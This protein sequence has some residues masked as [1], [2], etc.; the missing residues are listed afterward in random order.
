MKKVLVTTAAVLL[1]VGAF[2]Q[3]TMNFAT[4]T[5][6]GGL[7]PADRYVTFGAS[8]AA[9]NP[10]LVAGAK[11]GNNS[12]GVDLSG[13]RV[14]L[15]YA[16]TTV[17]DLTAF[18]LATFTSTPAFRSTTS[19]QLGTWLTRTATMA[20]VAGGQVMNYAAVV[21]DSKLAASPLDKAALGGLWG[22]SA[23]F[24]YTVPASATAAPELFL[25]QD[26]R[27]FTIGIV[28]E[29]TSFALLGLGAAAM[30]IFR[31]RS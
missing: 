17:S 11:V 31:R 21:W 14:A 26:L 8:A 2:A 12:F 29:P 4:A 15:L 27:G 18:S 9:Y 22:A 3:G 7:T 25:P 5:S 20:G 16:P 10:A 6:T 23:I 24:Q 28:P 13:L 30:L 1:T 19:D